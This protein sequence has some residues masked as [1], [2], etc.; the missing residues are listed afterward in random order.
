MK[1][2]RVLLTMALL[3]VFVISC[4]PQ[5]A[6]LPADNG[7]INPIN[8][9]VS[10]LPQKY[11]VERIGGS[12]VKVNA[13]VVEGA[14]P[15]T[16]EPKPEQMRELANSAAYFTIGVEYEHTWLD[17]IQ[18][19]NPDMQIVDMS[20][21]IERIPMVEHHHEGEEQEGEEHE[22]SGLDPHVWTSPRLV[23]LMSNNI[24]AAL[25]K[26]DP[27]HQIDFEQNSQALNADID[28]LDE[29]IKSTL[30]GSTDRSFIVFHPAWGYFAQDYN[31]RQ[32]PIEVEG[33]EPS[34]QE[35][36]NIINEA[37]AEH[38]KVVF[39]QPGISTKTADTIAQEIN[40]EVVLIN[41]LEENWLENLQKVAEA[42]A[43]ALK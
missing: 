27:D 39:A 11:L 33:Q 23:K 30:E 8:I 15:H 3:T 34:P 9:T 7:A 21:G 31:L 37:K 32:I 22:E 28:Q 14:S 5:A 24:L 1:F 42:F 12:H 40:G 19:A 16:Y 10:I 35:L 6:T 43:S 20:E 2:N 38:S 13:M 41:P 29:S 17:R 25:V 18:D 26:L 4:A 36:V